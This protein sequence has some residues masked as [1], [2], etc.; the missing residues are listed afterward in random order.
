LRITVV[1]YGLGNVKS[2]LA[3]LT[4]LNFEFKVDTNGENINA[5]DLL[6]IPGVASFGAGVE[7]IEKFNQFEEILNFRKTGKTIVGLCLGAQLFLKRS[8]E[9]PEALGLDLIKGVNKRLD[10]RLGITPNQG[11]HRIEFKYNSALSTRF[12]EKYFYFSHSYKMEFK[13]SSIVVAKIKNKLEE[14][15]AIIQKEN[16]IGLQFHPERSGM[17]GLELLYQIINDQTGLSI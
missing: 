13:D 5:A 14:I 12:E 6:V 7:N 8:E 16:L 17:D 9:S 10:P 1:D 4:H 15:P 11:W 2:V 3:A